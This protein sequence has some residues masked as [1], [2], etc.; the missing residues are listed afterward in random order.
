MKYMLIRRQNPDIFV[1][2]AHIESARPRL[3]F[4]MRRHLQHN[5]PERFETGTAR[6][7]FRGASKAPMRRPLYRLLHEMIFL[8][9]W[10]TSEWWMDGNK[11]VRGYYR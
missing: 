6:G 11:Q 2:G 1:C 3:Q 9:L 4:Y 7:K 8:R 10:A 5:H